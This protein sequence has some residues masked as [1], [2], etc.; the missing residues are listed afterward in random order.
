MTVESI[1]GDVSG[2]VD[3]AVPG[4]ASEESRVP[5]NRVREV[6][7]TIKRLTKKQVHAC[8]RQRRR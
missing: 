2:A 6:W 3:P 4:E 8:V 5:D 7:A 1:N